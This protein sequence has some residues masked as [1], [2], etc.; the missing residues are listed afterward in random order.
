MNR[1]TYGL[2]PAKS[3]MQL[4]WVDAETGEFGRKKLAHAELADYFAQRRP[5]R[6]AMEASGSAH[7][8]A[9][10]LGGL[11]HRVGL[12]P[13]RQVE[14]F[15]RSNKDDAADGRAS[16]LAA[17]QSDIRRVPLTTCEQPAVMA[18]HRTRS[19]RM[20]VRTAILNAL[21]GPLHEFGVVLRGGARR[22]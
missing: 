5:V 6:I 10:V 19:H 11:G 15:V 1:T 2:D 17:Q 3:V 9:R 16:W 4:H 14:P 20:A 7:H 12:L 18:L 21:R 8:W 22:A 13:G